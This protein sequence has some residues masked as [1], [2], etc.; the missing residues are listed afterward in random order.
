MP[1]IDKCFKTVITKF[2]LKHPQ[3]MTVEKKTLILS[4]PYLGDIYVQTTTNLMKS[5]KG[6]LNC[7]KLTNYFQISRETR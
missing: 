7:R 4:L 1:F 2:V 6:I 3:I 5:L